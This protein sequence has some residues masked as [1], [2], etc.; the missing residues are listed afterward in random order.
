M[1]GRTIA[2]YQ[3]LEKLGEGGMG[4][5]YKARDTHLDRFVAIKVLPP[6]RV[7]DPERKRRFV[8]EAK[9][10]SALNHPNI[11][12]IHDLSSDKGVD[13]IVMEFVPGKTL[14]QLIGRKGM[15]LNQV[16]KCA[17][18]ITDALSRAHAAGIVHRDLKPSNIMVDEHGLV[19]VLDFG[20]AKLT[21]PIGPEAETV[22]AR[23][24]E[25]TIVGTVA[26]MSPEQAEGKKVDARSDIFSFGAL[27]YEMLTGRR[28][29]RGETRLSTLSA[30]LREEPQPIG[31]STPPELERVI[32]RC[33]RKD[34]ER[35]IQHMGD[36]K[37][38]LQDLKEESESGRLPGRPPLR[39]ERRWR[40]A[41]AIAA[42]LAVLAA[43]AALYYF[44][45]ARVQ[46]PGTA[47]VIKPLTSF[48]GWETS[49]TWS[50]DGTLIA[51]SHNAEGSMDIYVRPASGGD[52]VRLTKSPTD[53]VSPRWSPDGRYLAFLADP[54]TGAN[55][56]LI[57]PLGGAE[58]KLV[59]TGIPSLERL[60]GVFSA[61]GAMPWSPE[62]QELLFSRLQPS[63]QIAIWK[64]SLTTGAQTQVTFPPPGAEDL[65]ASWSFDGQQMVF[66]RQLGLWIAPARGGEPRLLLGDR[67][68]NSHPAW[69]ADSR[70]IVFLSNRGGPTSL[71][72]IEVDS[73]RLRQLTTG[74]GEQMPAVARDG[75]LAYGQFS[76]QLDFYAIQVE[77]GAEERLTSH[78]HENLF[79]RFSPQG[80][81]IVYHSDRTGNFEIW[82]R[83]LETKVERQLTNHPATDV[84]PDWSPDGRE[85]VFLSNREGKSQVWVMDAEGGALRRL[86]EQTVPAAGGGW[87]VGMVA[88]RWSPDGKAIGYVA[89]SDRGRALW[90]ADPD[91]RNARPRLYGLLYFDW[92]RD[93]RRVIY[94]RRAQTGLPEMRVADLETGKEAVLLKEPAIELI[95]APDGR[96]VA[97]GHALSHLNMNLYVLPLIPPA[98]PAGLPQPGGKPRQLTE[99]KGLWHVHNGGWSLDG[100]KIVYTRDIDQGDI[101]AIENYR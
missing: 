46:P 28:A 5:V 70:R 66:V 7:A 4:V 62:G 65:S 71:W 45:R 33:L 63:G 48:P 41:A 95:A 2:H 67:Y 49:Q 94:V 59:E 15:P 13:F 21:E 26:Y 25:G 97:Y 18:Q 84:L 90:V 81:K 92:Y 83:D 11:I 56:Y 40:Y 36:V 75:R 82:L 6:E 55:V 73:G 51:Y 64:I 50:P 96:A 35:R 30:I 77:T 32:T 88:P 42:G 85:I 43:G 69:S 1:I 74:P 78:T 3:V 72:E 76:H 57:P 54:G 8:Q 47:W 89:N 60:G 80:R 12:T 23:T 17:V 52:P 58:R 99:G 29:F 10:A 34:P 61:L 38:A 44:G 86:A 16:L 14:E 19:K 93:S 31:E 91:G 100:K 24:A 68:L 20:L 98:S 37:L 87:D 39:P 79:P 53:E 22:T 101:Y 9:A 27:L